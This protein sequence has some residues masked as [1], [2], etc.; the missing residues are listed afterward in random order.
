MSPPAAIS[1]TM[2]PQHHN[3]PSK[4]ARPLGTLGSLLGIDGRLFAH[5]SEDDDV[6]GQMLV[7]LHMP[8]FGNA[9]LT[10][11][12]ALISEQLLDLVANLAIRNLDVVLGGAVIGH[13]GEEAI[14]SHI[15]LR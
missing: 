14:V 4:G 9:E 11:I 1:K 5:G 13:K 2:E 8:S 7:S 6:C 10:G 3:T 12:L 15:E